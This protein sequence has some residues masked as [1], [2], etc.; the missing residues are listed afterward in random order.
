[1]LVVNICLGSTLQTEFADSELIQPIHDFAI[2]TLEL[3][4]E[5][6]NLS[7]KSAGKNFRP[8]IARVS[9]ST[10]ICAI[11]RTI[12]SLPSSVF[13][14]ANALA[15]ESGSPGTTPRAVRCCMNAAKMIQFQ[16]RTLFEH[17]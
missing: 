9:V 16:F 3:F 15:A 5:D 10:S 14:S 7:R 8:P 11:C 6:W 12:F 13:R 17:D 4:F 1:M 2:Q